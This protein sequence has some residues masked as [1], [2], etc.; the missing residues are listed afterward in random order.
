MADLRLPVCLGAPMSYAARMATLRPSRHP[1]AFLRSFA[2]LLLCLGV[3]HAGPTH[4][5]WKTVRQV[6]LGSAQVLEQGELTFGILGAP[7]AYGVANRLTLQSH[8]ILDLLLVPNL[9]GR[10]KLW[11]NQAVVTALTASYK[12]SFFQRGTSGTYLPTSLTNQRPCNHANLTGFGASPSG[13]SDCFVP[14]SNPPGELLAGPIGTWYVS[15]WLALTAAPLY[16]VRLGTD[17]PST[18][19][20]AGSFSQGQG[21]AVSLEVHFLI[22]P[23]DLLV[24][25]VFQRYAFTPGKL[26]KT[27]GSLVWVHPF[28]GFWDGAHLIAGL[29][30]GQFLFGEVLGKPSVD[31]PV[32]PTI[33]LWWRR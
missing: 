17:T 22:R 18:A 32:F 30:F 16:A 6:T 9:A 12:Q 21:A 28:K 27:I 2:G 29:Q 1:S 31:L 5:E 25:T 26:D 8:P 20:G 15:R 13:A 11:E 33:D 14:A 3:L 4:A 10:Y 23:E 19:T 7:I 24:A